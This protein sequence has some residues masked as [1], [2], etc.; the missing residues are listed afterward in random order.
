MKRGGIP[1]G[2]G[3][4]G[5]EKKLNSLFSSNIA[6]RFF[7]YHRIIRMLWGFAF[8]NILKGIIISE[9]KRSS[10]DAYSIYLDK[11]KTHNLI[12]LFKESGFT[13]DSDQIFF[14]EIIQKCTVWIG[15]YP[16]PINKDQM[17]DQSK[18]MNTSDELLVRSKLTHEML[19]SGEIERVE[20]QSD[21]LH[22]AIGIKELGIIQELIRITTI[23]FEEYQAPKDI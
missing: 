12:F 21:I 1:V 3:F 15:R 9:L 2:L 22:S 20:C 11:I 10:H 19:M 23:K 13:L 4:F 7:W 8:E 6:D 16:L 17:Y 5:Q 18:G 14:I